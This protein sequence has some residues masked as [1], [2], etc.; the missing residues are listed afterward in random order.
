MLSMR[1]KKKSTTCGCQCSACLNQPYLQIQMF[2]ALHVLN[3]MIIKQLT[4]HLVVGAVFLV[5]EEKECHTFHVF[6]LLCLYTVN[7]RYL[8]SWVKLRWFVV[9]LVSFAKIK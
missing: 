9:K 5:L 8:M 3:Y 6:P 1:N 4:V 7:F 2:L